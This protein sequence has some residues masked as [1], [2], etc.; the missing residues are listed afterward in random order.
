MFIKKKKKNE[1]LKTPEKWIF[2]FS[3]LFELLSVR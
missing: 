2:P 1:K 3:A